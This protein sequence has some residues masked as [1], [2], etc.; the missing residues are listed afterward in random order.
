MLKSGGAVIPMSINNVEYLFG[1]QNIKIATRIPFD[2]NICDFLDEFSKEIRMDVEAKQYPD[3]LTFAFW[4]RKANILKLKE[5]YKEN[6]FRLGKG[7]VFHIAPSNVP[8]NFAYTFVFGLLSGNS[9]VVKASS[10]YF[11]QTEILC[12]IMRTI[13]LIE[14]YQWVEEQNAIVLYERELMELTEYY[15]KECDVRIIWGG[16]K[17]IQE[18]RKASL[19]PRSTEITFS[20][21]YSF[22]I[23]SAEAILATDVSGLQKLAN[24]FYNDTYLMDQNACSSPHC[25]F[26]LGEK[27]QIEKASKIFWESIYQQAKNYLME[28]IKVSEKYTIACEVSAKGYLS[29]IKKY[30]NLLYVAKLKKIPNDISDL[31]GRFGLFFEYNIDSIDEL[32]DCISKKVQTCAVYGVERKKIAT[33]IKDNGIVGI[34]RIVPFGDTLDIGLIW[35][36]YDVI[37]S[38][39]RCV[40]I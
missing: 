14:K 33:W 22:G 23:V 4:I 38:L 11:K 24:A 16:D 6:Q 32:V 12:R 13:S 29:S 19:Q 30:D 8:I 36:G 3:I 40:T 31:R 2:E 10:K 27:S 20:D 5:Q 37:R 34:D 1:K 15:S 7:L 21:R 26:W 17:T 18:I 35:D 28:E 25:I 9:N 39:S